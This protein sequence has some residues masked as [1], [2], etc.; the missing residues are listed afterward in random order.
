VGDEV[1]ARGATPPP[2]P[3]ANDRIKDKTAGPANLL[4][5][6]RTATASLST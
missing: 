5:L 3:A 2:H 6:M 4:N 1:P